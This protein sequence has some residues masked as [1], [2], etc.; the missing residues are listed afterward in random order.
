MKMKITDTHAHYTDHAF[1]NDRDEL[2]TRILN[3][4]AEKIITI[5]CSVSESEEAVLL[6]EKYDNLYAA[7]GIHPENVMDLPDDYLVEIEA[8]TRNKKVIAIG[9]IGLD[10]HYE[11]YNREKQIKVFREQLA[12]A[13]KLNLPVIIHSRDAAKDTMDILRETIAEKPLKAQLHCFSGSVETAR[14]LVSWGFMVSFTC[15]LTYKNSKKAHTVCEN[16]PIENIMLET[17]CPY[18][19]PAELRGKRCDSGMLIYSA[20]K[21]AQIKKIETEKAIEICNKNAEAFF[22]FNNSL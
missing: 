1:D 10:Y 9:E 17:D 2:L 15:S 18:M 3:E 5:G 6:A 11:G 14:E 7:V 22:G 13:Q 8:L 16:I 20:E 19:A 4:S 21:L 12:L